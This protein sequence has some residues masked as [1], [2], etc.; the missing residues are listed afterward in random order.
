MY[1]CIAVICVISV[2]LVY[3]EGSVYVCITGEVPESY[4]YGGTGRFS[5]DL[6][7]K[8]YGNVFSKNDVITALLDLNPRNPTI[9]YCKN[10]KFMGRYLER[11]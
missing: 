8:N 6:K 7:F 10:G 11:L 3:V 5:V 1:I 2:V 9:S 4:G